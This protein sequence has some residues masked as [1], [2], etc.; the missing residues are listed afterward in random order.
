M[1]DPENQAIVD[2]LLAQIKAENAKAKPNRTAIRK[3]FHE[4]RNARGD[5]HVALPQASHTKSKPIEADNGDP[6]KDDEDKRYIVG[7]LAKGDD[8]KLVRVFE[9]DP[10]ARVDGTPENPY[11][12]FADLVNRLLQHLIAFLDLEGASPE[13]RATAIAVGLCAAAKCI[14]PELIQHRTDEDVGELLGVGKTAVNRAVQMFRERFP[15]IERN[16][17]FRSEEARENMS[18]AKSQLTPTP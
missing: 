11:E 2:G 12:P 13:R 17:H 7:K 1:I 3:W 4:I 18:K 8:G 9:D 10:A 5:D 14:N 15:E 6:F 16:P